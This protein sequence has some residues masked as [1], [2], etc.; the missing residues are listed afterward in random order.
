MDSNYGKHAPIP[1]IFLNIE[2]RHVKGSLQIL[3]P[4]KM[5][6]IIGDLEDGEVGVVARDNKIVSQAGMQTN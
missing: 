2:P 6:V 3:L 4:K 5:I 1:I